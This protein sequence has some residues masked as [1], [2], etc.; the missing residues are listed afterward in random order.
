MLEIKKGV[1]LQGI[2]PEILLA[3]IAA[4]SIFATY[5]LPCVITSAL[6]GKH[7][8]KSLHYKGLAIDLRTKHIP[9]AGTLDAIVEAIRRSLGLQY[10]VVL[11][12]DHIHVEYDPKD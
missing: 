7:S 12:S 6:D 4:D 2:K 9:S 5:H 3:A 8:E 1:N 10:D 11:E